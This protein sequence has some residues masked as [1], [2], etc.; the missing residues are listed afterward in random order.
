M[1]TDES[2]IRVAIGDPEFSMRGRPG[3]EALPLLH[4]YRVHLPPNYRHG[5]P[6]VWDF[7]V[8]PERSKPRTDTERLS[9]L[10]AAQNLIDK[11]PRVSGPVPLVIVSTEEGAD[12]SSDLPPD[13]P[14]V[15]YIE[16]RELL[17]P[18][19]GPVELYFSPFMIAIRKKLTEQDAR[20]RWMTPYMPGLPAR[21]WRFFGREKELQRL[22]SSPQN[23]LVIGARR[24]GKTS[25]LQ[26]VHRRMS[27]GQANTFYVD[28]QDAVNEAVL[29][30]RILQVLDPQRHASLLRRKEVISEGL[31]APSLK[32]L[33]GQGNA[34]LLIDEI[35][36]VITNMPK[37]AWKVLGV[38]RSYAQ[39]GKLRVIA[40]ASQ[41]FFLRQQQDFS[42]PW[43]NFATTMRLGGFRPD[44]V[45]A[46]VVKP[47][48]L[49]GLLPN[50]TAML[51]LVVSAVG[52]NPYL[53][54]CFCD[55]LFQNTLT[56][57]KAN[58]A[59]TV[60]RDIVQNKAVSTFSEVVR[61][62]FHDIP[63]PTL[64]Y[65]FVR[66]CYDFELRNL[67]INSVYF[68]LDWVEEALC[69][70]GYSSTIMLRRNLLEALRVRAL[71]EPTDG[72]PDVETIIAPIV[73]HVIRKA[74]R[75]I[76]K[77]IDK[78][79]LEIG[80]EAAKIGLLPVDSR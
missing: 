12:L 74:E 72:N 78:Y 24:I 29:V 61:E 35:G 16:S 42:G 70:A 18:I 46:F 36:N 67:P 11:L 56:N 25:L 10:E 37:E 1:R 60:A 13:H 77:L 30:D 53:L 65:L 50:R 15:F 33:S 75:N 9:V 31:L 71:T 14:N 34:V 52:S 43:V 62:V 39:L 80:R 23:F 49:W 41:E 17:T 19:G 32:T 38:I 2:I 57:E 51:E 20:S 68:D 69:A 26:E 40:T 59:L 21:D 28:V 48:Q 76:E 5:F 66:R 55:A 8:V 47:F 45:D 44:E 54:A 64:Q 7:A 3:N 73:Y 6:S 58:D 63:S 4:K 79:R 22:V 27:L